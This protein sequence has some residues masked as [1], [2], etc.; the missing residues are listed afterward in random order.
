MTRQTTPD[1]ASIVQA[2]SHATGE[3]L[4][5]LSEATEGDEKGSD[6]RFRLVQRFSRFQIDA[7]QAM[8]AKSSRRSH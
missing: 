6:V 1:L 4:A 7:Q 8:R 5:E 3:L 2:Y